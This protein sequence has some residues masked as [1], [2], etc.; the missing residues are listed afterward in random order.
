MCGGPIEPSLT[1]QILRQSPVD[2]RKSLASDLE[3]GLNPTL[4]AGNECG[5]SHTSSNCLVCSSN[6][7]TR[8][9]FL[10]SFTK[11]PIARRNGLSYEDRDT[12]PPGGSAQLP[13]ATDRRTRTGRKK[14]K[15]Q[16]LSFLVSYEPPCGSMPNC[17][18]AMVHSTPEAQEHRLEGPSNH[19]KNPN[20]P[21][22][23]QP[24]PSRP[25]PQTHQPDESRLSRYAKHTVDHCRVLHSTL[26]ASHP[27]RRSHP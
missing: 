21:I 22:N 27:A 15:T 26:L 25:N 14:K 2:A 8:T 3:S 18:P 7:T 6:E 17:T 11:L 10:D 4:V 9:K 24:T 23:N 1:S 5:R 16:I 20:L 13:Q 19:I 12:I